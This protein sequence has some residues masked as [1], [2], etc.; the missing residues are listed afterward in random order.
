Q[1][2]LR[3]VAG[4]GTGKTFAIMRRVARLLHKGN[5][6][7]SIF[8]C[9]FTR[10]AAADLANNIKQMITS[11]ADGV[12][13]STLHSHCFEVLAKADVLGSTSRVP[14]PLLDLEERFLLEDLK[15]EQFG[16]V[17][18][19][20]KRLQAFNAAWARLQHEESGWCTDPTDRGY[21]D[22]LLAWLKFHR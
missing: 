19:C 7:E 8:L 2:P 17:R 5:D 12:K 16:T 15:G 22:A 21:R 3:V 6:P 13:T 1:S 20:K 18:D 9:S 14:R 11:G 4:P 10:T